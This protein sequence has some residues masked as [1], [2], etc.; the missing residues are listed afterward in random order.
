MLATL[1]RFRLVALLALAVSPGVGGG[2]VQYLHQCPVTDPPAAHHA[3]G[4]PGHAPAPHAPADGHQ[5]C[6]C[7]G[8]CCPAAIVAPPL[9]G[10]TVAVR[11]LQRSVPAFAAPAGSPGGARFAFLPPST[12]PPRPV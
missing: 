1:R 4:M 5:S 10:G 12:A 2:A 8:A 11:V 3:A 7:I 6:H 9:P